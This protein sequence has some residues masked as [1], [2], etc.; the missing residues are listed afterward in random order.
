MPNWSP[1]NYGFCNPVIFNDP[2]GNNP[3]DN[4]VKISEQ[5]Q[6]R[7]VEMAKNTKQY[8]DAVKRG[9]KVILEQNFH[10]WHNEGVTQSQQELNAGEEGANVF[11]ISQ[12]G[13][14]DIDAQPR[15]PG[16]RFEMSFGTDA[17]LQ[18]PE[19]KPVPELP[20]KELPVLAQPIESNPITVLN[21]PTTMEKSETQ[22]QVEKKVEIV[23]K[24][25]VAKNYSDIPGWATYTDK[26]TS[27]LYSFTYNV[28]N[29]YK[30]TD[31]KQLNVTF[32]IPP[33]VMAQS[34]AKDL[35][36]LAGWSKK[37]KRYSTLS[38]VQ[39]KYKTN[40]THIQNIEGQIKE[41][42][43]ILRELLPGMKINIHTNK[44]STNSSIFVQPV[45]P[46]RR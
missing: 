44:N 46:K 38:S 2:S 21:I 30:K 43:N 35:P 23:K 5:G 28:A 1:Y 41:F 37:H 9:D 24:P 16:G 4:G 42:G 6:A 11:Y 8:K 40:K 45:R 14:I 34:D 39:K 26:M 20:I 12:S 25:A 13:Y 3:E 7:L 32:N 22:E 10:I 18:M 29:F 19:T 15:Y 17:K 36:G 31:A 27:E 33:N